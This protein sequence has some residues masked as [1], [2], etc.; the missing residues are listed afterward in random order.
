MFGVWVLR[1]GFKGPGVLGIGFTIYVGLGDAW[2]V[3]HMA[4]LLRQDIV[5]LF[6][7]VR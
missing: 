5:S 7:V 3:M 2:I 4:S 1:F 6:Q